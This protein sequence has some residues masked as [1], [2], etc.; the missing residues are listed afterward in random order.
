MPGMEMPH[1]EAHFVANSTKAV[2]ERKQ[3]DAEHWYVAGDLVSLGSRQSVDGS[4]IK[5]RL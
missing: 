4:P 5:S 1:L 3:H 2:C